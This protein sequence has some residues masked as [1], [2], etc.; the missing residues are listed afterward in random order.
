VPRGRQKA[1][2]GRQAS[3]GG[4]MG[5]PGPAEPLQGDYE[6]AGRV[7][8]QRV[9]RSCRQDRARGGGRHGPKARQDFYGLTTNIKTEQPSPLSRM[10]STVSGLKVRR[11]KAIVGQDVFHEPDIRQNGMLEE[12]S[13]CEIMRPEE[14]G[15]PKTG[16][17]FV[18]HSG[19]H[20]PREG[21]T[22][23]G[24]HLSDE[25]LEAP[26]TNPRRRRTSRRSTTR[27][28]HS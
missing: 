19:R 27:T 9:R 25:Q 12:P 15:V 3:Q 6:P 10:V 17:V 1:L 14:V 26:S 22:E 16:L 24:Y 2:G 11:N 21:V 8:D 4:R 13:I 18:N 23:M 5:P 28:W 7:R 20:A